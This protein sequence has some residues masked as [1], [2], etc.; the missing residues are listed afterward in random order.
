MS[1]PFILAISRLALQQ[2]GIP[3]GVSLLARN[4]EPEVLPFEKSLT[5]VDPRLAQPGMAFKPVDLRVMSANLSPERDS[6]LVCVSQE[7]LF[8]EP[9]VAPG[10]QI[11]PISVAKSY[12]SQRRPIV[13]DVVARVVAAH[14]HQTIDSATPYAAVDNAQDTLS[15]LCCYNDIPAYGPASP[16]FVPTADLKLPWDYKVLYG[17][18]LHTVASGVAVAVSKV[19]L[20][21]DIEPVV[22][23]TGLNS[24]PSETPRHLAG[25]ENALATH[26]GDDIKQAFNIP[27][28]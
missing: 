25:L 12:G 13:K 19:D 22:L 28:K 9:P 14:L 10:S 2:F 27:V 3:D 1:N 18:L 16:K 5:W 4:K 7:P 26:V 20:D 21:T 23:T 11:I 15:V 6:V 17:V 24:R 8:D